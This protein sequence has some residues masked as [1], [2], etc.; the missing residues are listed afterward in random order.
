[1]KRTTMFA[2]SAVCIAFLL[3]TAGASA[4][5]GENGGKAA[6]IF[7]GAAAGISAQKYYLAK[8]PAGKDFDVSELSGYLGKPDGSRVFYSDYTTGVGNDTPTK[9]FWTDVHMRDY[10]VVAAARFSAIPRGEFEV[11]YGQKSIHTDPCVEYNYPPG[12]VNSSGPIGFAKVESHPFHFKFTDK[13]TE[14]LKLW[15]GFDQE[16]LKL[17]KQ[18][19]AVKIYTLGA[20]RTG[21]KID[22]SAFVSKYAQDAKYHSQNTLPRNT[23]IETN[24]TYKPRRGV[25]IYFKAGMFTHGLPVGGGAYSGVGGQFVFSYLAPFSEGFDKLY[26]EKYGYFTI[27][28]SYDLR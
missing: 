15:F 26:S 19:V 11:G 8:K 18:S 25:K 9:K 23:N 4:Y 17:L 14:P 2:A 10:G 3:N 1:V 20:K 24:L 16:S 28:A 12:G 27:G 22:L 5:A 21:K 13:I 7:S 6:K